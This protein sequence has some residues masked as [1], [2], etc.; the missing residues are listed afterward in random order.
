MR[1]IRVVLSD[2]TAEILDEMNAAG[3]HPARILAAAARQ[4]HPYHRTDMSMVSADGPALATLE[5]AAE[6]LAAALKSAGVT[7]PNEVIAFLSRDVLPV[8][9]GGRQ[10]WAR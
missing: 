6:T 8:K 1:E 10:T 4:W 7:E 2:R 3:W 9:R 5:R